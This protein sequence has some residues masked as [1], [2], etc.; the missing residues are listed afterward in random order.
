MVKET[1]DGVDLSSEKRNVFYLNYFIL[2]NACS[3][4]AAKKVFFS[5]ESNSSFLSGSHY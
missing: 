2:G 4:R 3:S 1:G 5:L